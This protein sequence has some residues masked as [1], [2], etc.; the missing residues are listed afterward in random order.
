MPNFLSKLSKREQQEL[1]RDLNYLNT[2]EIKSFC[3][4]HAIP[5]TIAYETKD[6]ARRKTH[7]DD[8]K[9]V[10]LHRVRHFLRTGAVLKETYFRSTVVCF[11]PL[12]QKLAASDRL[13]YGQ[14]DKSNQS[15]MALLRDLTGGAFKDGAIARIL[16]RAFWSKGHAPT[17]QEFA[18]AWVQARNEHK[19][20]NPEWAFLADLAEKKAGADWKKIRTKKAKK[21]LQTLE[22][23]VPVREIVRS[24]TG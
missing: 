12:P 22:Q 16:A 13:F 1:L 17:F 4:R 10:M 2:A 5:Y 7:E 20:P 18:D 21:V 3:K 24:T 19:R 6:G 8:R 14:Y 15:R 9:G 23:I 11:D